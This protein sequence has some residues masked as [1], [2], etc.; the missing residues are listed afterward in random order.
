MSLESSRLVI[1]FRTDGTPIR[2]ST[3]V[4]VLVCV[5]VPY[6][7]MLDLTLVT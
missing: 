3:G 7:G 2:S 4:G 6:L 5:Q 1:R